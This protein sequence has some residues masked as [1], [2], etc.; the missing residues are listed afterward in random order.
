MP[1][2]SQDPVLAQSIKPGQGGG[3]GACPLVPA[4][5]FTPQMC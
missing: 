5:P 1:K 3:G 2:I 4:P